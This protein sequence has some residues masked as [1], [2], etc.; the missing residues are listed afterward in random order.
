MIAV[1]GSSISHGGHLAGGT[2]RRA[3]VVEDDMAIRELLRL[4]LSLAGF[5]VAELA[6]GQEA[7]NV[8]QSTVFDLIVM[9][10]MLPGL[11][12]IT[13]CRAIRGE[14]VNAD[15]AI[16][17][18]TARDTESDKVLGLESGADDYLT[19]PFGIRE[20][21]ARV[22]AILRRNQRVDPGEG[23]AALRVRSGDV[24]LDVDKR[25]AVV[26]GTLVGL[27]RQ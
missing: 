8:A 9:D 24:A 1:T 21:V 23:S 15:S 10:V 27:T 6:D 16:L 20:L 12:G 3:L 5:E 25:R 17:M 2:G 19:K 7:L 13:I 11:D 22:G 4:H 14:G 26:R 18:L